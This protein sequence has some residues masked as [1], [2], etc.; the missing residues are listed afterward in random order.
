MDYGLNEIQIHFRD[1]AKNYAET[2][3]KPVFDELDKARAY[4]RDLVNGAAKAGLYGA[5]VPE[6]FGGKTH[7]PMCV[8]LVVEELAKVCGGT[9]MSFLANLQGAIPI[10]MGGSDSQKSNFI[11]KL[12]SGEA[13]FSLAVY[14]KEINDLSLVKTNFEADGDGFVLNGVK[15]LV[16]G[17]ADF[18]TVLAT[19]SEGEKSFFVIAKDVDG[20][21]FSEN[22]HML[23]LNTATT[24]E[25][26]LNNV[27]VSADSKLGGK[28][29]KTMSEIILMASRLFMSSICVGVAEDAH[30]LA[31]GFIQTRN[32]FGNPV[33]EKQAV[34]FMLADNMSKIESSRAMIYATARAIQN[35]KKGVTDS[36]MTKLLAGEACMLTTTDAV[37]LFGGYGYMRDYPVEKHFRDAKT[38]QILYGTTQT[39]K[40]FIGKV[41]SRKEI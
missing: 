16:I 26:T 41:E 1:L 4:S 7:S 20:V 23:G 25:M 34:Q 37:Q 3:V 12:N 18:Y 6:N 33:S 21:S 15:T 38:A 2:N 9:A 30:H 22:I 11:P 13:I 40:D 17:E 27:K 35:G 19:N 29:G 39:L 10:L 24:R 32:Q 5:F 8:A 14:E 36:A 28:D 31:I